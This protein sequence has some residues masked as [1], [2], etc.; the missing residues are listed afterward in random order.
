MSIDLS[1]SKLSKAIRL[2]NSLFINLFTFQYLS[3]T[4]LFNISDQFKDFKGYKV[5]VVSMDWFPFIDFKRSENETNNVVEP[6]DSLD[7]RMLQAIAQTL[8]FT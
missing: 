4:I 7:Y 2:K 6:L 1:S 5:R 8:N 3:F